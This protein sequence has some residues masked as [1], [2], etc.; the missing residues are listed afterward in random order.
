MN[1]P[2]NRPNHTKPQQFEKTT[3]GDWQA[4]HILSEHT[5]TDIICEAAGVDIQF[6]KALALGGAQTA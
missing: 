1:A 5:S 2:M 6:W 4:K 3:T